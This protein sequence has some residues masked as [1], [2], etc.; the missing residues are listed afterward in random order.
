MKIW[1]SFF[2][3]YLKKDIHLKFYDLA[4]APIV[5]SKL[6]NPVYAT[7][8]YKPHDGGSYFDNILLLA[9]TSHLLYIFIVPNP[10]AKVVQTF[11]YT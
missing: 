10:T 3:W 11:R 7:P 9:E 8:S 1:V 6:L 4:Q 5:R 2:Y